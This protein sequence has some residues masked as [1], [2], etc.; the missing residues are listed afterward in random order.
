LN[1]DWYME[2]GATQKY[3]TSIKR[4]LTRIM[5]ERLQVDGKTVRAA[6]HPPI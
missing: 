3:E 4:A 5:H 1:Y 2:G 6:G